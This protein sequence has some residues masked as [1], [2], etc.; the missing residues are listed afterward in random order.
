[1]AL[2][3]IMEEDFVRITVNLGYSD[4]HLVK[5]YIFNVNN[6]PKQISALLD[7]AFMRANNAITTE[8]CVIGFNA[9]IRA[10]TMP[11]V[12]YT[13]FVSIFEFRDDFE[14]FTRLCSKKILMMRNFSQLRK[15]NLIHYMFIRTDDN[16]HAFMI[17]ING[18]LRI[19]LLKYDPTY[20]NPVEVWN[21]A[22]RYEGKIIQLF[23]KHKSGDVS[24]DGMCDNA[25]IT[26]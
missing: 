1:M 6:F 12:S 22:K 11:S 15:E 24:Y 4:L 5:F 25:Y 3:P 8:Q 26:W 9:T 21:L 20:T 14:Y 13:Y 23:I 19:L 18:T 16:A 7:F 10:L 2:P 17:T